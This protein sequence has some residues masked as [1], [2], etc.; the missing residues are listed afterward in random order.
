[1]TSSRTLLVLAAAALGAGLTWSP[2][3]QAQ[4]SGSSS[5]PSAAP[6]MQSPSAS[7]SAPGSSTQSV[8]PRSDTQVES[9]IKQLHSQLKITSAQEDQWNKLAQDMRDNAQQMS[10]LLQERNAAA[11]SRPMNAVDNLKN[12]ADI[13][14]AHAQGLKTIAPDFESLYNSMSAAQK[15]TADTI[16]NQRVN[17]RVRTTATP[18]SSAG[19]S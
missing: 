2:L 15:K 1:M 4:S 13:A 11:K 18:S 16:F 14:D 12:Y 7:P 10:S 6:M 5:A 17:Q 19:H 3:A 9:R 8:K